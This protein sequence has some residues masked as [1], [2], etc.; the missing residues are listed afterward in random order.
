[1]QKLNDILLLVAGLALLPVVSGLLGGDGNN[2]MYVAGL[3]LGIVG[4]KGLMGK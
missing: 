3:A 4:V 2:A 1:M